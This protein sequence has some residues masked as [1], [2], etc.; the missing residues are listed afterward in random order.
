MSFFFFFLNVLSND[1]YIITLF[2]ILNDVISYT[3]L[4]SVIEQNYN[5]KMRIT[6]F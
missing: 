3:L 4:L 5:C 1:I 6:N 2:K